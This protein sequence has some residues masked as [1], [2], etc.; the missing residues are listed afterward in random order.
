MLVLLCP[1]MGRRLHNSDGTAAI[2]AARDATVNTGEGALRVVTIV[3]ALG[4]CVLAAISNLVVG[5][6]AYSSVGEK[7]TP[8]QTL[9]LQLSL[10]Y[11]LFDLTWSIV[12]GGETLLLLC[13]HL[14][15]LGAVLSG[16][17]LDASGSELVGSLFGAEISQLPLQIR[18]FMLEAGLKGTRQM[19]F[20]DLW[21]ALTFLICRCGLSACSLTHLPVFSPAQLCLRLT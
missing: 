21:F 5:P 19:L 4:I 10:G 20:V 11:F 1:Q 7:N 18:W 14:A 17:F 16:L 15:S 12:A 8:L 9:T 2:T 3:Y 6:W 13:H